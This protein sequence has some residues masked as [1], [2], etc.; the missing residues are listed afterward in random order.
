MADQRFEIPEQMR[1]MAERNVAQAREAYA[2]FIEAARKAQDAV[3]QSSAAMTSGARELQE[4]ALR[5]AEE[6]IEAGFAFAGDLAKVRDLKEAFELQQSFA[7][8]QMEAFAKQAQDL[9][10]LVTE[11]AQKAQSKS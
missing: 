3:A 6:N 4:R 7:R 8:Q 10:R 9:T 2:Q 5:Y 11:A 1:E